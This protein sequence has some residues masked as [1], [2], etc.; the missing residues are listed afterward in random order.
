MGVAVSNG[1][2]SVWRSFIEPRWRRLLVLFAI[3]GVL[4]ATALLCI[5]WYY[6]NSLQD[7]ALGVH[8]SPTRYDLRVSEVG[9]GRVT[10]QTTSSSDPHGLWQAQGTFGLEWQGGYGQISGIDDLSAHSVTRDFTLV[11]GTLADGTAVRADASAF[12]AD[13]QVALGLPYQDVVVSGPLG[14]MPA[15]FVDGSSSTWAILVHGQGATRREMLRDLQAYHE[16]GLKAL[17]ITYRNDEGAP[18]E[19]DG[20]YHFGDTEWQDLDAAATYASAHGATGL[21]LVGHS[22]GGGIVMSFLYRSPAAS[23]ARAVI[24]DSPLLDLET[25]IR[26][27]AEG[28]AP[29]PVISFGMWASALR[30]GLDW[31]HTNYLDKSDRLVAPML[32]FHGDADQTVPLSTSVDLLRRRPDLV[33]LITWPGVGHVRS[34]N[35]DPTAYNT[36]VVSFL[37]AHL[38]SADPVGGPPARTDPRVEWG[39]TGFGLHVLAR[40]VSA[41]PCA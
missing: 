20:R 18:P 4:A 21:V 11:Q 22:M 5:G 2:N 33:T 40:H 10:L 19:H 39:S 8:H 29:G 27:R 34:W 30:F 7:Q 41:V 35:Y 6:S 9:S 14:P 23:L 12:P 37:S 13:P 1:L 36:A 32:V 17:V 38:A 28:I 15:W 3:L 16:A 26:W 31:E 25:T 24:L